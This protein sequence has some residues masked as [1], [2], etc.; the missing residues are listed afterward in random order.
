MLTVYAYTF[1]RHLFTIIC[2]YFKITKRNQQSNDDT[3]S[4]NIN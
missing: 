4:I 3:I 1:Q 2:R